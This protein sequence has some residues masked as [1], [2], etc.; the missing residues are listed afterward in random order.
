MTQEYIKN[1]MAKAGIRL[2]ERYLRVVYHISYDAFT[3][4]SK[5]EQEEALKDFFTD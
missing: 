4:W 3:S 2:F 5:E 1:E